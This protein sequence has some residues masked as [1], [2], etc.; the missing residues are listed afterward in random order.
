[1]NF[2]DPLGLCCGVGFL[3]LAADE[4]LGE[5]GFPPVPPPPSTESLDQLGNALEN[6]V[7]ANVRTALGVGAVL[8][9]HAVNDV[10]TAIHVFSKRSR[11]WGTKSNREQGEE[12]ETTQQEW[13]RRGKGEKI[14]SV[15]KGV[16]RLMEGAWE[17]GEQLLEELKGG[18]HS[19]ADDQNPQDSW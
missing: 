15:A 11:K 10:H 7:H 4:M 18:Q 2:S 14:R 13:R 12:L 8:V 6:F 3:G 19:A 17:E 1:M 5:E 9:G 16:Q